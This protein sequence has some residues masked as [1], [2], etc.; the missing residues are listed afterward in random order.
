MITYT[1]VLLYMYAVTSNAGSQPALHTIPQVWQSQGVEYA[2]TDS[3]AV[4]NGPGG[5]PLVFATAKEG[6]RLDVFD[7]ATGRYVRSIGSHGSGS[8]QFARPNGVI[9]VRLPGTEG[10]TATQSTSAPAAGGTAPGKEIILVIER[11]NHRV[12][13]IR[14]DTGATV[15]IIGHDILNRPY[16]AAV[17]CRHGK[18]R[19]YVTDTELPKNRTIHMF[20]L[21]MT[22]GGRVVGTHITAFGQVDG[23]GVIAAAESL[24]VDDVQGRLLVCDEDNNDVKVYTLD[25]EFTGVVFAQGMIPDDPEGIVLLNGTK[26]RYVILTDQRDHITIWHV[27]TADGYEHVTSFTGTPQ[28]ANTD[29]ICL[30]HKPLPGFPYGGLFAVDDDADIR[31]YDVRHIYRLLGEPLP[32]EKCATPATQKPTSGCN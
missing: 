32:A 29:G 17:S 23:P 2:N 24:V 7:V 28:V 19:L 20:D 14:P 30:H 21:H 12:Q 26:H 22:A 25:G 3:L 9:T 6:N 18:V 16:G 31:A 13:A 8:G 11:D 1:T 27:F 15:G 4:A 10:P 5:T